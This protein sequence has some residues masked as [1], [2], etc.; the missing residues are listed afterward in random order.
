MSVEMSSGVI[1]ADMLEGM[2]FAL[3]PSWPVRRD[4]L[5][6]IGGIASTAAVLLG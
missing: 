2:Q 4:A 3:G 5:E 6:K 1:T